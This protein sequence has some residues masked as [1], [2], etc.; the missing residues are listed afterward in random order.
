MLLKVWI[1][2]GNDQVYMFNLMK[3]DISSKVA[4]RRALSLTIMK[5]SPLFQI[6]IIQNQIKLKHR[7]SNQPNVLFGLGL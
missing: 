7:A 3:Y 4:N 6:R 1:V 5:G 2:T